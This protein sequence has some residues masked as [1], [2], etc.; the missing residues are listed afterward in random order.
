MVSD[1]YWKF[2]NQEAKEE[3]KII[4]KHVGGVT[5]EG[6]IPIDPAQ[7]VAHKPAQS[8]HDGESAQSTSVI[9]CNIQTLTKPASTTRNK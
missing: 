1:N 3:D 8:C 5:Y 2:E 9:I 4:Y 7:G 6:N